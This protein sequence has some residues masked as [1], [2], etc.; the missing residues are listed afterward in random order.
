MFLLKME[1]VIAF[2]VADTRD[3]D[4]GGSIFGECLVHR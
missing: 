3:D 1:A 4:W 2:K